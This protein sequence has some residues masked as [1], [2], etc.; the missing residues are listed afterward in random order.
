MVK[1]RQ[2]KQPTSTSDAETTSVRMG[3]PP[4]SQNHDYS[5]TVTIRGV[6]CPHCGSEDVT[7]VQNLA[8]LPSTIANGVRVD[9]HRMLCRGCSKRFMRLTKMPATAARSKPFIHHDPDVEDGSND[10]RDLAHDS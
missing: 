8:R 6:V 3:R 10:P 4:G 1:R 9:R 5:T 7:V 2:S